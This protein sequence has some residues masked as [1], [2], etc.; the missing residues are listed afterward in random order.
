MRDLIRDCFVT[1]K[2]K[3]SE[4]AEELLRLDDASDGDDEMFGDFEDLE[5]GEKFVGTKKDDDLDEDGEAEG[6]FLILISSSLLF[7]LT[8]SVLED[9][10]KLKLFIL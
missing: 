5:T 1:G 9:L 6:I 2:W 8:L 7:F 4:D 3:E 10:K